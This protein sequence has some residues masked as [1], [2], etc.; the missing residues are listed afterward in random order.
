MIKPAGA[1][2]FQPHM[3]PDNRI[4][5]NEGAKVTRRKPPSSLLKIRKQGLRAWFS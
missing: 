1:Y 2:I 5:L 4:L 3:S